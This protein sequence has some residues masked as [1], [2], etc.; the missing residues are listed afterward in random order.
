MDSGPEKIEPDSSSPYT[1]SVTSDPAPTDV[2][3]TPTPQ[4]STSPDTSSVTSDPA[5][6]DIEPTPTPQ[7]QTNSTDLNQN[8]TDDTN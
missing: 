4:D 8:T 2:E 5:P 6:S 1:P 3:P 7:D